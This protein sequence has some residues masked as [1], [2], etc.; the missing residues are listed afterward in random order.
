MT[1]SVVKSSKEQII[2]L[3]IVFCTTLGETGAAIM[4]HNKIQL[5]PP[6]GSYSVGVSTHF[7]QDTSVY[8]DSEHVRPLLVHVYYPTMQTPKKYPPY[9]G[10][11]MHLYKARLASTYLLDE[12]A[13]L[14]AITDCAMPDAPLAQES[15]PFPV[16]FFAHGFFMAAQLYS[17]LIEEMASHGYVVVAINHTDACW[18][19]MFPDGSSPIILPELANLFSNNER[20]CVQTFD[21]VQ[22][23]WIKDIESVLS[24]L[25]NQPLATSLD[26]ARMGVFGHSFGGSTAIEAARQ[27]SN[28]KAMA[29]LDGL[30]FGQN[31]DKPLQTPSLFVVAEK[32]LTDAEVLKAGLT[33]EQF[34]SL[35]ARDCKKV[36]DQLKNDA[37]YVTVKDADHAAFV[38]SK[39]IKSPL[40]NKEQDPYTCI[41]TTRALLVDFFDHY[42]KYKNLK[43]AFSILASPKDPH[44]H[45]KLICDFQYK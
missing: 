17:S 34:E 33:I 8:H 21:M 39:L 5:P 29:N 41:V 32:L 40:S 42:L 13:Y 3:V 43:L 7:I 18:P 16:L 35:L 20:S 22:E 30:L 45:L 28:F 44:E 10:D 23:T 37:F 26:L 12:L 27:N 31:W 15:S 14:D 19:V 24:W 25:R 38:D 2:K 36:F 1:L 11:A 4:A 9:L 6:T